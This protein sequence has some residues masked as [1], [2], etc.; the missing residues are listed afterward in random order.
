MS[1]SPEGCKESDTSEPLT[2]NPSSTAESICYSRF[3]CP[4]LTSP[5]KAI[6]THSGTLAW[7]ISWTEEPGRQ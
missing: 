5:E 1:Y 4:N 6:A 2:H 7:K 3:S